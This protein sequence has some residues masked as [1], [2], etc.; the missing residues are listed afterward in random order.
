MFSHDV[1]QQLQIVI[2]RM[3]THEPWQNAG[4]LKGDET[5]FVTVEASSGLPHKGG[6]EFADTAGDDITREIGPWMIEH[7]GVPMVIGPALFSRKLREIN[8][9]LDR[10]R[11][12]L[13]P[14]GIEVGTFG[15]L[16]TLERTDLVKLVDS[17]RFATLNRELD[18]QYGPWNLHMQ[19]PGYEELR[20]TGN[21]IR[22]GAL[23]S[24]RQLHVPTCAATLAHDY[25]AASMAAAFMIALA[26]NSPIL[27]GKLASGNCA[28]LLAWSAA[29]RGRGGAEGLGSAW[30]RNAWD[31]IVWQVKQPHILPERSGEPHER[32]L[33]LTLDLGSKYPL[34]RIILA[35]DHIRLEIRY[36]PSG[37]T[38]RDMVANEAGVMA[39]NAWFGRRIDEW[40]RKGVPFRVVLE[41]FAQARDYGPDAVLA[42]PDGDGGYIP[43]TARQFFRK[44]EDELLECLVEQRI[45]QRDAAMA[46][47]PLAMAADGAMTGSEWLTAAYRH[48]SGQ[49]G[50]TGTIT[51]AAN[52]MARTGLPVA[53]WPLPASVLT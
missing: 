51:L 8:A 37:L 11:D 47:A 32:L 31:P 23:A 4:R 9:V 25:N 24:S 34:I 29:V 6:S 42:L 43:I 1:R 7:G 17:H 26:G 15:V 49:P 33:E 5:E 35:E 19:V 39:M 41:N 27:G 14:R 45:D 21:G 38:A 13:G 40:I 36:L 30:A 53:V 48:T 46:L 10:L 22:A 12:P 20:W 18:R 50:A 44:Y 16:P 52:E 2:G 28:R 3:G